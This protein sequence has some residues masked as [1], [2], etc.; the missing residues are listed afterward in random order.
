[1]AD[2]LADA[3]AAALA[4]LPA[5]PVGVA[6]S[7]GGDS[8]ALMHL[9]A[10]TGRAVHAVTVDHALRPGSAAEARVA[11]IRARGL[12][13]PHDTLL[14]EHDGPAS[15]PGNLQDAARRARLRLIA[16]WAR[17]RGLV[18]VALGHTADDQA[19]TFL[20][21]LARGSGL[22]GLSGMAAARRA[23][24][25]WWLRPLL[26]A[27]RAELRDWLAARGVDWAEDP[28]NADP[29]FD[30][31]RLRAALPELEALG[32]TVE[33]LSGAAAS[34]ARAAGVVRAEVAALARSAARPHAAGFVEID[35]A[36]WRAAPEEVRL[37]L[38]AEALRWVAAADY[39]PRLASLAPLAAAVA[40]G[41]VRRTLHGCVVETGAGRIRV[42]REP[43]NAGPPVPA[44]SLWDGRWRTEGPADVEVA[45]LGE[46]GLR[47]LPDWRAAGLPRSAVAALPGFRR[48][49]ALI[50]APFAMPGKD[51]HAVLNDG[52]G[53]FLNGLESS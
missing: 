31:A 44:G 29:R 10:G 2:D 4:P 7:G 37:R 51:C 30:R 38:L 43:A 34:L 39:A 11:A 3:V 6:V 23:E 12:G 17:G 26:G 48:G 42:V 24:G 18:A 53:G 16:D 25:V 21:R 50:A 5:G 49:G 33:R 13:L 40:A 41:P 47:A 28:G 36:P 22:Y 35:A 20:M 32:L 52:A 14:W 15:I 27:R 46:A 1:M 45:V 8:L 19:E 9:M